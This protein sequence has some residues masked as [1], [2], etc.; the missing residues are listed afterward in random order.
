MVRSG[1]GEFING[2]STVF[3]SA[4]M[5]KKIELAFIDQEASSTYV[6]GKLD[7]L[8]LPKIDYINWL[9]WLLK[10][11]KLEKPEKNCNKVSCLR[12]NVEMTF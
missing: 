1:H 12:C 9:T 7:N 8:Q 11:C 2:Q 6:V 3:L 10:P 5:K 4:I